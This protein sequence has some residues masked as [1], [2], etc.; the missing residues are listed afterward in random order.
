MRE[1]LKAGAGIMESDNEGLTPL[2]YACADGHAEI[3]REMLAKGADKEA[4]TNSGCTPLSVACEHGHLAAAKLLIIE[5][6]AAINH[7]DNGGRSALWRAKWRVTRDEA[8]HAAGAEFPTAAERAEHKKLVKF[9]EK[10]G[11]T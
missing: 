2:H 5:H 9:L 1:L 8:A 10:R 3:A 6:G 4:V 11:A 7:L